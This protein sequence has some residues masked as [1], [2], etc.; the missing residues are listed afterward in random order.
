M[1]PAPPAASVPN[2]RRPPPAPA[3]AGSAGAPGAAPG[4]RAFSVQ[5]AAFSKAEQATA[6]AEVLAQRGYEA[7]VWGAAAPYRVR[8]GRVATR[9][10]ADALRERLQR[11]RIN[12]VVVE[13]EEAR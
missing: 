6:L 3:G 4:G 10:E 8:V 7:R 13:A 2:D 5:V 12:G 1:R 9:E 11:S